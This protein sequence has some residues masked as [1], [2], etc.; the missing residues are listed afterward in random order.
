MSIK[1]R[2]FCSALILASRA[3]AARQAIGAA[4]APRRR[5]S[6]DYGWRFLAAD[7]E[8]AQS[9]A[10]DAGKWRVV[11]LPHDWSI[12]GRRD[13][14]SPMGGAGGFFPAG[15]GWYRKSFRAPAGWR[16]KRVTVEFEGV[17]MNATVYLNG[18]E[19]GTHPYG[20]TTFFYELT[21]HLNF[22][23]NNLLAVRVD[24]SKQPNSRCY[25]GSGIYRHVWLDVTEALHVARW[26]V[27]AR[28]ARLSAERAR[29]VLSVRVVNESG[30]GRAV[31]LRSRLYSPGGAQA[32]LAETS[33]A[34]GP[35][36]SADF[37]L[38]MAVAQPAI[39][40]PESP[41]LYRAVIGV[42]SE[43]R[44]LD[45]VGTLFGIRTI[46]W[47]A[48]RGL[49][50][51]GRPIKL[52]GGCI[53]HDNGPLGA[54]AFDRAE[55]RRVELLKAAGFN[56]LRTAHNPPSPAFLEACDRLGM[57][58]VEEA[59][60]AWQRPKKAH[61]YST[62]FRQWWRR[63]L[64]AMVLRDR[65][66]PSVIM[67]SIGNEIPERGEAAGA[68]T[69]K[70]LADYV[71]SLDPTRPV[72]AALNNVPE[73]TRT[74]DFFAALDVGGYNYNLERHAE[75]HRR[76]PS[77]IMMAAESFPAAAY[78]YRRMV[79]DFPYIIGDFVWTAMDYLGEAGIGRSYL[80]D[81][82][83]SS[84]E[85]A[86]GSNALYPWHGSDCGDLDI[87]GFR[88]AAS[89]YRNLVWGRGEKLYLGVRRPAPEGKQLHVTR[90]GVW[91]IEESWTWPGM[92]GKPLEAEVYSRCA[93]VRLYLND[94]LIGEQAAS[95]ATRFKAVFSVPYAPGVLR[96]VGLEGGKP[97]AE[98][99]L[100]TAGPPVGLR[101]SPD[102][103]TL[104]ADGQDLAFITVTAVDK[105]ERLYPLADDPVSFQVSGPGAIA[106]VGSADMRS[107]EPYH[108]RERRLFQGKALV[109]IRTTRTP[110]TIVLAA[111][112]P[113]LRTATVRLRSQPAVGAAPL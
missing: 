11:D 62:V 99:E 52:A 69:A 64:E 70:L 89:H 98:A 48:E 76:V 78:E 13:P 96:A 34:L 50:L 53:H 45:E 94:K 5:F 3:S 26:G 10:F 54:A 90:W 107:E 7:E 108:A 46:E 60:D 101:L 59:F 15:V 77:R 83:D 57:L 29:V 102:R 87:C 106:G 37:E 49:L 63:D 75:D 31:K 4:A 113:G 12:E 8:A 95:E 85:L 27:F 80:R 51:N 61:D 19:L 86:M 22:G 110:G 111:G 105:E 20:Y 81:P 6:L 35:G 43:D 36:E 21:P 44:L 40:S 47:S 42:F 71:R 65:N 30:A 33:G 74:D 56:A 72:T 41:Q 109:I 1:R 58:V 38:E 97:V 23:D 39:W 91:P 14:A 18:Q 88:K 25:S 103:T 2:S 32:A 17:Y 112:A 100:R 82:A 93:L 104:R 73:W 16:G 84:K 92:E 55:Q 67:W 79:A 9:P 28:T 24:Q 68:Q 66:H